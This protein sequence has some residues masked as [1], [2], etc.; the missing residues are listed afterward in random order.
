MAKALNSFL[1]RQER[2]NDWRSRW[3]QEKAENSK[4]FRNYYR[5]FDPVPA[6]GP[7]LIK[8]AALLL[9]CTGAD[10][11]LLDLLDIVRLHPA[12]EGEHHLTVC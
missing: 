9:F 5:V 3:K 11:Q 12:T 7:L 8:P 6:D 10:K 1:P 4:I 2:S